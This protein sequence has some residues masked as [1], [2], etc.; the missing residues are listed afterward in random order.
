MVSASASFTVLLASYI[1]FGS[2]AELL[3]VGLD[4]R[5]T[6]SSEN[7]KERR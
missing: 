6:L 3:E 2:V 1:V 4:C 7:S 5:K